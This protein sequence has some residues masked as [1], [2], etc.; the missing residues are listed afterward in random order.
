MQ[1]LKLLF[2]INDVD[3]DGCLSHI[4]IY[5]LLYLIEKTFSHEICKFN[6]I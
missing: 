2:T 5:K 1:K 6:N 4:E 3:N